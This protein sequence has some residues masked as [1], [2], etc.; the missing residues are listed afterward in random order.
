LEDRQNRL[1]EQA[2]AENSSK[3]ERLKHQ[4][5]ELHSSLGIKDTQ[6]SELKS[7]ASYDES[8]LDE[9]KSGN[10]EL[11]MKLGTNLK[12]NCLIKFIVYNIKFYYR[13]RT[14]KWHDI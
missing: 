4:I 13:N 12:I 11:K 5:S 3:L 10:L 1:V 6:I 9:L 14:I 8:T 7:K 2:N